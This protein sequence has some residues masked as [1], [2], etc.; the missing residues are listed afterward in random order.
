MGFPRGLASDS[1]IFSWLLGVKLPNNSYLSF[2]IRFIV[3]HRSPKAFILSEKRIQIHYRQ[4]PPGLQKPNKNRG[5]RPG[6]ILKE[7][8]VK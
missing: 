8:D 5:Q 4:L 2:T 1:F 6:G 3:V 7:K